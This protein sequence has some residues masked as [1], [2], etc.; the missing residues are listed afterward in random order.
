MKLIILKKVKYINN[1]A[2]A[3]YENKEYEKAIDD[4]NKVLEI[5]PEYEIDYYEKAYEKLI[6]EYIKKQKNI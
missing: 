6:S 1:R 2:V 4:W 3:Y 5:E